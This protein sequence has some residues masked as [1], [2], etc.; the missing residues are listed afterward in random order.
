AHGQCCLFE[1]LRDQVRNPMSF[2]EQHLGII[3]PAST[4]NVD[5]MYTQRGLLIGTVVVVAVV[6]VQVVTGEEVHV[7]WSQRSVRTKTRHDTMLLYLHLHMHQYLYVDMY[8]HMY[9]YVGISAYLCD[10]DQ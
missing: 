1:F 4:P 7:V 2:E 6:V 8:Q 10:G 9:L 3:T 5:W